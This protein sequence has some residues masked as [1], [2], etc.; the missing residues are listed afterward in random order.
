M[1]R[2]LTREQS[3]H[4]DPETKLDG[5][6]NFEKMAATVHME[7]A[8]RAK[9]SFKELEKRIQEGIKKWIGDFGGPEGNN[10]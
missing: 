5:R 2:I 10:R 8:E 4:P 1:N 3:S 7:D 6:S 9:E